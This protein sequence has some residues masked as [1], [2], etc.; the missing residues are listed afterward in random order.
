MK[1]SFFIKHLLAHNCILHR[2][3]TKYSI[4][5]N[6]LTGKKSTVPRHPELFVVFCNDICKQLGVPKIK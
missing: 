4:Y 1:R 6:K 2:E 5:Q 3:G